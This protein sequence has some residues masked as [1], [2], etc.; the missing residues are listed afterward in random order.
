MFQ[1]GEAEKGSSPV[2]KVGIC[3]H[4]GGGK[5]FFDGQTVKTKTIFAELGKYLGEDRVTKVDTYNWKLR[6]FRLLINFVK[7]IN[8]SENVIIIPAQNGVKF[9]VPLLAILNLFFKR[10]IY[11]VV[12]GGWLPEF[13]VKEKY[14]IPSLKRFNTVL[15]ETTIMKQKLNTLGLLNVDILP[16]FKNLNVLKES[17]LVY[18]HTEPYKL[19]TFSR[20]M[21][22]KGIEDALEAVKHV[23]KTM[24][25]I[26]Y[27]LDIYGQVDEGYRERFAELEKTFP[28]YI[29][30]KGVVNFS[31]SVAVLK[32]Y[33]A[34]LFPTYYKGEGFAGTILDA[35][36]AG[37]PVIATNWR[38]NGEIIQDQIDGF[39]Y[40]YQNPAGLYNLLYKAVQDPGIIIDLKKNCINRAAEFSAD[41]VVERLVKYLK[42]FKGTYDG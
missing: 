4:F 22:E 19:C 41:K 23:N 36:A 11:Y 9:F 30:Y 10:K 31:D 15:V 29:C 27:T 16:N 35:Y 28:N 33:F 18:N 38:Y 34:L 21:K 14:L 2:F 1:S 26:V 3:G 20:V 24:G 42:I 17:E 7:L 37:I 39:I 25:R 32:E 6:P 5:Q 12:V 40:D 13:I 8:S